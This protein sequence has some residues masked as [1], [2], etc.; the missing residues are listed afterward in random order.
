[1]K[2]QTIAAA[3]FLILSVLI[4]GALSLVSPLIE[5]LELK[6]YDFMMFLRGPDPAPE[7]IVIVAIDRFSLDVFAQE[8]EMTWPWDRVVYAELIDRLNEAG[9]RGIAFDVIFDMPAHPES[10]LAFAEAIRASQA[11]VV[12]AA[13]IETVVTPAYSFQQE[14][15]PLEILIEAGASHAYT[16]VNPD[17]DSVVRHARLTVGGE[18]TLALMLHTQLSGQLDLG[19]VPVVALE[20]DDPEIL[21]NYVGQARAIETVSFHQ[22]LT[23]EESLPEGIFQD[24]MIFVGRSESIHDLMAQSGR[25]D[26]FTSPFDFLGGSQQIPGAEIHANIFHTLNQQRFIGK[27]PLT[28]VLVLA[29]ALG[30]AASIL[31]LVFATIRD[32]ILWS[33]LLLFGSMGVTWLAFIRFDYWILGFQPFLVGL[34]AVSMNT[35]YQYRTTEKERKQIEQMLS[36]YVSKDVVDTIMK[37]PAKLELGGVEVEATV[38]FSDIAGFSKIAEKITPQELSTRLNDYFTRM[39]DVIMQRDGMINKYIG[40]AIMAIWGAPLENERHSI[41]ACEAALEMSRQVEKMEGGFRTRYGLNSGT[42]VAGN[43]GHHERMEYTVIGDTVNLASRLEGANKVFGTSI[44]ISEATEK[45]VRDHFLT[46]QLDLI[47]V[48]GRAQPLKVY[49]IVGGDDGET[50][51]QL[52]EMVE[53]FNEILESYKGLDWEKTRGLLDKHLKTF[54][55]DSVALVYRDR[56]RSFSDSPPAADWDGVYELT[57]K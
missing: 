51:D 1:M 3:I 14:V 41:L 56:C 9:V 20:E 10:D 15:L 48:V 44:M 12:L 37:D 13:T 28:A 11:P 30:A 55:E 39:G 8:L 2:R 6:N 22:V 35:V 33:A 23:Y 19:N 42:M 40:D 29:L 34:L 21:I 54:P 36:G 43:L 24:Q 18:P 57:A 5:N 38:L 53:S 50:P 46:R 27:A 7:D 4:V 52:R 45:M 25:A 26:M 32:R 47:R 17:R 16:V 49:Q 31:M